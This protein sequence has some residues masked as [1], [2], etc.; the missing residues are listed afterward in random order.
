MGTFSFRRVDLWFPEWPVLHKI[1]FS[2]S[3]CLGDDCR[4]ITVGLLLCRF[5]SFGENLS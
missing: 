1:W 3:R 2:L 4:R 5:Q